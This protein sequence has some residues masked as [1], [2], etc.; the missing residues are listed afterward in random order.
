M[1]D[2]QRLD[3]ETWMTPDPVTVRAN[4]SALEAIEKMTDFGIRHL[5]VVDAH[6]RLLGILSI[7]DV[8]AALP[9]ELTLPPDESH[10]AAARE[11][12]VAEIMTYAPLTARPDTRLE[13]AAALLAA[14][15]IGCLPVV[16]AKERVVGI[17]SETDA[18][19]ALAALLRTLAGPLA[20]RGEGE[21]L[22]AELER[23]RDALAGELERLNALEREISTNRHDIPTDQAEQ[24]RDMTDLEAAELFAD[25]A[26]TRLRDLEH[27]LG[28]ARQGRL[29]TCER[30]NGA[31]PVA[32]LR[33]L[34]G[35]TLCVRCARMRS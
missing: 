5:P 9:A 22:R 32:R 16:D 13:E 28:R 34:P 23:E 17:L 19:Q 6:R 20:P 4:A 2:P 27:A 35:T 24:G 33:A 30:C 18:L 15:R 31:I 12:T 11:Q 7:D 26:A 3:V 1:T 25:R 29:F 8:R 14:R 10:R 21:A